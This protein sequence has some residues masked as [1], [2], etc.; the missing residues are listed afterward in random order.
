MINSVFSGKSCISK[1]SFV[2]SK[3]GVKTL[4]DS[5]STKIYVLVFWNKKKKYNVFEIHLPN[6]KKYKNVHAM[7]EVIIFLIFDARFWIGAEIAHATV[8]K[9]ARELQM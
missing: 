2:P 3:F 9:G 8:A 7:S 5:N 4:G 1:R 6:N